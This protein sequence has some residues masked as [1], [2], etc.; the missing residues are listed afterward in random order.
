VLSHGPAQHYELIVFSTFADSFL[1]H[2]I[3]AAT[4]TGYEVV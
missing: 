3:T 2:V 4:T 1:H